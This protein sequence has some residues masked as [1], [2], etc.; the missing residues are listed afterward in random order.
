MPDIDRNILVAKRL[1]TSRPA[2]D[3][4]RPTP[5]RPEHGVITRSCK[6]MLCDQKIADMPVLRQ[7]NVMESDVDSSDGETLHTETESEE[8]DVETQSDLDFIDDSSTDFIDT[9][10]KLHYLS[11]IED[12]RYNSYQTYQHRNTILL[13][14]KH[15]R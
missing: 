13:K 4:K 6:H 15:V 9:P 3:T 8:S 7:L 12:L 11:D 10:S 14:S 5:R 1:I 2:P